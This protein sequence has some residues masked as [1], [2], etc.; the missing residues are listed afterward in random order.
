MQNKKFGYMV[1][2]DDG[3]KVFFGIAARKRISTG[4]PNWECFSG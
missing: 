2:G 1:T 4:M 3:D